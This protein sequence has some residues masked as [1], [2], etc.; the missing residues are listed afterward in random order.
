MQK[1]ILTELNAVNGGQARGQAY[2]DLFGVIGEALGGTPGQFYKNLG[3]ALDKTSPEGFEVSP[4]VRSFFEAADQS[5]LLICQTLK[6]TAPGQYDEQCER[7][8][9]IT[10]T[11]RQFFA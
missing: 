1:L 9:N 11:V 4:E 3:K 2:G 8:L 10:G 6:E 5:Q 7:A